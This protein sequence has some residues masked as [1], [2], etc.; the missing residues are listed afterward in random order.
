M[1]VELEIR[2]G[3]PWYMSPDIW[4]VPGNDPEGA[5]G[6][7]VA[8]QSAYMWAHVRN[9]G[10]TP[11]TNAN[12]R[13]YWA[14]PSLGVTRNSA[15]LIGQ[16]FVS[17]DGGEGRDVLCLTPW[18]PEFV[19]N[20][21]ECVVAE[22]FHDSVDPLPPGADFNV[23]T[24]RHVAQRNLSVALA[25]MGTSMMMMQMF[26]INPM[27]EEKTFTVRARQGK[28]ATLKPHRKTLGD[29]KIPR[30]DGKIT[31]ALTENSCLT[32][33]EF[34]KVKGKKLEITLPPGTRKPVQL[35]AR[36]GGAG[37]LIHVE[38][39]EGRRVIGGLSVLALAPPKGKKKNQE[40]Y[41]QG[42]K[43]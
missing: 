29:I 27:Q 5:A 9:K 3:D 24:D 42:E 21:H 38:Q 12:V 6:M 22:A 19:N 13:Y 2:D 35:A 16:S 28:L 18:L 14:D 30:R 11:V 4:I 34:E 39:V 7:P 8:G 33:G 43:S 41:A 10:T 40:D 23:K 20:G 31:W 17:L 15:H 36:V 26:A 37:A 32:E 1:T 25:A